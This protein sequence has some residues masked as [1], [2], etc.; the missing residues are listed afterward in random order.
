MQIKWCYFSFVFI[1]SSILIKNVVIRRLYSPGY[2]INISYI[3]FSIGFKM[4]DKKMDPM[5]RRQWPG[6]DTPISPVTTIGY[7]SWRV[8]AY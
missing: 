5:R 1:T 6:I 7:Q 2:M 4:V 3:K 8:D